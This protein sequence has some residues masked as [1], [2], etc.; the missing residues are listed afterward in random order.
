MV[1]T[2]RAPMSSRW[3]ETLPNHLSRG[4]DSSGLHRD[5]TEM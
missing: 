3:Q 5:I 2:G 1:E 4:E